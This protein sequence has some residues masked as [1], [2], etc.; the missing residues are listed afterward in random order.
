MSIRMAAGGV[1]LWEGLLSVAVVVA[2]I[3]G[4][5]WV[6]ARVYAN[7]VLRF[8]ARIHLSDALR[9]SQ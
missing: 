3:G 9:R 6:G 1:P 4:V 5:T 7:S 8:G 2:S